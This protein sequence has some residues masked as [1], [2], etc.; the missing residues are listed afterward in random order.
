M[1]NRTV[2]NKESLQLIHKRN[3]YI[4]VPLRMKCG[5]L[6]RFWHALVCIFL[7][8]CYLITAWFMR[9]PGITLHFKFIFLAARL[10]VLQRISLRTCYSLICSLM[11]STRYFEFYEVLKSIA[12]IP[13][14]R[15]LDVSSPRLAPLM[16]LMQ[17]KA[18]FAD[19]INPDSK[20]IQET[21]RLAEALRLTDLCR[22]MI[23]TIE[24]AIVLAGC[25]YSARSMYICCR[26]WSNI[27]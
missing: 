14:S 22:F 11:D 8:P 25:M 18:A 13:F 15:Y 26:Y 6:C 2:I 10:F 21:E 3:Q 16:L 4:E 1:K 17:N 5:I 19:V 27:Y 9:A 12:N 7:L 23:S 24:M 20:D